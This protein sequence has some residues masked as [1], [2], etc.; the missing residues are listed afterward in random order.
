MKQI[1]GSLKLE[2][3]QFREVEAFASFGADALDETTRQTL[4]RGARLVELL[5]QKPYRPYTLLL[6]IILVFAGTKGFLDRLAVNKI[7]AFKEILLKV[8][9]TTQ[10]TAVLNINT[11][12]MIVANTAGAFTFVMFIEEMGFFLK[13]LV[14]CASK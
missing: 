10:K 8:V 14:R 6:E 4:N 3:A 11:I 2:L 9:S 12:S 5:K 1:A 7:A 13:T